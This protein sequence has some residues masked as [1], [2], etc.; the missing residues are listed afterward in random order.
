M[1][2][3]RIHQQLVARP[4][5]DVA[6]EVRRQLDRLGLDVPRGEVAVT[7][8]SR[9]IA[10]VARITR[11]VGAWLRDRGARPFVVPCM[12]SHGGATAPG[13]QGVLAR[14]GMTAETLGMDIRAGMDVV[15]LGAVATGDVWMDARCAGAAGVVVVNR[16]KLHTAFAGPLQSGL[17][18]MMVVGMGKAPSA[19][20][21]HEARP[22][23]MPAMLREMGDCVLGSGRILAGVAILEDG[24]DQ[25]AEI[26]ALAARD[27][28]AREPALL[29]RHRTYF[30][31]LP[32]DELNVLIVAEIG[33]DY[34][35]TGMD[36]NVIGY[37][38]IRG[39]EDLV[40][41]RIRV[42]AALGLSP[43]SQGNAIGVGLADFITQR[44][45][46]AIHE[47]TTLTNVLTTGEMIRAKI[48]ATLATDEE[49][50]RV[51]AQRYGTQ[52]W[53]LIPNTLHL[54]TAYVSEDL[55]AELERHPAC[56]VA[57][58]S[59]EI[60]FRHGVL[61]L[62]WPAREQGGRGPEGGG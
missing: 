35:G 60:A 62:P 31:R 18:K 34:S 11:A 56:R 47:G 4:L 9:G 29:A 36:T 48:P 25:T 22:D 8:G 1:K 23:R 7:A 32:A 17:T 52:R 21:F 24:F 42:I 45:R 57:P 2:V 38:G 26:H 49:L 27:I 54:E 3:R 44:L 39:H 12:G 46:A 50:L 40:Q 15:K 41:P 19:R 59:V 10:N 51:L 6:G 43:A 37:R 13:Q 20:T 28:P 55:A 30:P 33:K 53:M 16:V 5:A 58:E 14:L 61:D